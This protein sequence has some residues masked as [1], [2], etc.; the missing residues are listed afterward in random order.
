MEKVYVVTKG[1]CKGYKSA[2]DALS[3]IISLATDTQSITVVNR[4]QEH[5]TLCD[6]TGKVVA[7]MVN[8]TTFEAMMMGG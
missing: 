7:R 1:G 2:D 5:Y 8:Q 6:A 3:A 4:K